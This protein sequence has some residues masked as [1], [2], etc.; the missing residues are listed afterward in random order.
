MFRVSAAG[1]DEDET[2]GTFSLLFT[3][4]FALPVLDRQGVGISVH[5]FKCG[6]DFTH[7][8]F[9]GFV[10]RGDLVKARER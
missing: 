1:L 7:I 4:R 9:D 10:E 3:K 5:V 8:P 6:K 2:L